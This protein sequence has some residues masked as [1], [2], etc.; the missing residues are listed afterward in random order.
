M[1]PSAKNKYTPLRQSR[2]PMSPRSISKS[3]TSPT[4]RTLKFG[5]KKP[6]YNQNYKQA[7]HKNV[8]LKEWEYLPLYDR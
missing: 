4:R 5:S 8:L 7:Y 3:P 2:S 6:D 1:S